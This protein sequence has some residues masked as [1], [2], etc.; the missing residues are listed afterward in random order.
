MMMAPI[1]STAVQTFTAGQREIVLAELETILASAQFRASRRSQEFLSYTVRQALGNSPQEIKERTI[2]VELFGRAL[3]YDTKEDAIVRVKANEIRKRLAVYYASPDA[4]VRVRID[5]PSGGYVPEF[6]WADEPCVEPLV[7]ELP[8][9][10]PA[11]PAPPVE[12]ASAPRRR[13]LL[14]F[15][16]AI[17]ILCIAGF[18]FRL[19]TR[20]S[21]P[22]IDAFWQPAMTMPKPALVCLATPVVYRLSRRVHEKFLSTQPKSTSLRPYVVK[23]PPQQIDGNDVSPVVGQYVGAGDTMA[24]VNIGRYFEQRKKAMQLRIGQEVSFADLRSGPAVLIGAFSNPWT[25][26]MTNQLRFTFEKEDGKWHILDKQDPAKKYASTAAG[27]DQPRVEYALVSRI[28]DSR[29]GEFVIA[30]AGLTQRGTQS[31]GELLTNE[32]YLAA[33][34]GGAPAGWQRKNLQIVL[35][36]MII[37]DSPGPPVAVAVHYW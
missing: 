2:G 6:H 3:D 27:P 23:L 25:L 16:A 17:V 19:F 15:A 29:S 21:T 32:K 14:G 33:A 22:T 37:A 12:T 8:A 7:D 10:E 13:A 31:T 18:S 36:A 4:P 24:A 35:R 28:L 26:E 20:S 5:L 11:V 9:A 34:L 30:A 1:M